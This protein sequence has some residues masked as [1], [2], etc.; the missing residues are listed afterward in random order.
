MERY[1][2]C[3][4]LF[5]LPDPEVFSEPG[6]VAPDFADAPEGAAGLAADLNGL[7]GD[8]HRLHGGAELHD[9]IELLRVGEGFV[10]ARRRSV[11]RDF[12]MD[13][14]RGVADLFASRK[15]GEVGPTGCPSG[16]CKAEP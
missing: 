5:G 1:F 3:L 13:G 6:E 16:P 7:L 10:N 8:G 11:K 12:L 4:S 15:S 2:H 14:F 9:L